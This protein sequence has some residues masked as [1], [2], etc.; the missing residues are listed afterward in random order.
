MLTKQ[1]QKKLDIKMQDCVLLDLSLVLVDDKKIN[2]LSEIRL[3][4]KY[5]YM[6]F[7]RRK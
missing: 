6:L 7:I 2:D 1:R 5:A 3:K 4:P